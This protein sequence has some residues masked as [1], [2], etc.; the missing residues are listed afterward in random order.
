MG[1]Q[2]MPCCAPT[3]ADDGRTA[4]CPRLP[5]G[6]CRRAVVIPAIGVF[7]ASSKVWSEEPPFWELSVFIPLIAYA[8]AV[9]LGCEG[10]AEL[11]HIGTLLGLAVPLSPITPEREILRPYQL[12][13]WR[14]SS[15]T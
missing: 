10:T 14:R 4:L 3:P 12:G 9:R 8:R 1:S 2:A 13:R 11:T 5:E 15:R 7:P 6:I